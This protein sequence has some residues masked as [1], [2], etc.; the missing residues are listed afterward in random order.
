MP[1]PL[2]DPSMAG[3]GRS[4]GSSRAFSCARV[5]PEPSAPSTSTKEGKFEARDAEI[6]LPTGPAA[7]QGS[8]NHLGQE[9]LVTQGPY[10]KYKLAEPKWYIW[11]QGASGCGIQIENGLPA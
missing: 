7:P 4:Y 1:P 5:E 2:Q 9:P 8:F 6:L 11:R 3:S 10:Y